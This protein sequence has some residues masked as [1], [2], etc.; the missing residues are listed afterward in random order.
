MAADS[1]RRSE[2]LTCSGAPRNRQRAEP[3]LPLPDDVWRLV[4]VAP[5]ILRSEAPVVGCAYDQ[6]EAAFGAV[7]RSPGIGEGAHGG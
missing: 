3:T 7:G 5:G 6:A 2:P 4:G 1:G